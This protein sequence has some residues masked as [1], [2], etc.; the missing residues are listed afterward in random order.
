MAFPDT[1]NAD[2]L[3][4]RQGPVRQPR[5]NEDGPGSD[6]YFKDGGR[7]K[8]IMDG[9]YTANPGQVPNNWWNN[10]SFEAE[11]HYEAKSPYGDWGTVG[12]GQRPHIQPAVPIMAM[13]MHPEFDADKL[14]REAKHVGVGN[15]PA[16]GN[17]WEEFIPQQ[18]TFGMK[19][20]KPKRSQYGTKFGLSPMGSGPQRNVE[21]A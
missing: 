14:D 1:P 20:G 9:F 5:I 13:H 2:A 11:D 15:A 12:Q 4:G 7:E 10:K 3:K 16:P 19:G 17:A 8:I 6:G 21:R 18:P